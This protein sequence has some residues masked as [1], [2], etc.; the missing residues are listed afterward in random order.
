MVLYRGWYQIGVDDQR[1]QKNFS[2]HAVTG[3]GEH[4][5]KES[6]VCDGLYKHI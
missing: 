2:A 1:R 4:P 5:D 6:L 3:K